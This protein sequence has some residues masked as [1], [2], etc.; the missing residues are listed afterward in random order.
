[1]TLEQEGL[2]QERRSLDSEFLSNGEEK[3]SSV[4]IWA[5]LGSGS[6]WYVQELEIT[7]LWI[8]FKWFY[9]WKGY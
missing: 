1:M 4:A 8:P 2:V 5:P 7:N 6:L 3:C 9:Q